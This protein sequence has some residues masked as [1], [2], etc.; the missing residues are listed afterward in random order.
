MLF[1]GNTCSQNISTKCTFYV[2]LEKLRLF[3]TSTL[4]AFDDTQ[5]HKK[6]IVLSKRKLLNQLK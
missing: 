6:E 1:T 4:P 2:Y 5:I 3:V